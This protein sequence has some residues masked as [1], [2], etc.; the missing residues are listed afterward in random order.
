M[1]LAERR[2]AKEFETKVYPGWKQKILAAAHFEV[3]IEVD[4]EALAEPDYAHLYEEC[5]PKVYFQSLLQGLQAVCADEMGR[6]ALRAGLKKIVLTN[7]S[8][9]SYADSAISFEDGVLT[10]DHRPCSNVDHI[11]ERAQTVQKKL[12]AKL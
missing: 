1:G 9:T 5:W 8:D 3:P 7:R 11:D 10:I 6:E 12:E 4:W 2:A